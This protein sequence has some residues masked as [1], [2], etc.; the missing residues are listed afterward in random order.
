MICRDGHAENMACGPLFGVSLVLFWGH[1]AGR[2]N[3][4]FGPFCPDFGLVQ[5]AR[6]RSRRA[7]LQSQPP[8]AK[9][10]SKITFVFSL[11]ASR[12]PQ[13]AES[14]LNE[15]SFTARLCR[16]FSALAANTACFQIQTIT[17]LRDLQGAPPRAR[18]LY[19]TFPSA[20]GPSLQSVKSTLSHL[21]SCNPV[22]G[23]P[24]STS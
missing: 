17:Y 12:Q 5:E 18:Q 11:E 1:F 22:R 6:N 16:A 9:R 10:W 8:F 15:N 13:M 19:F 20:P 23:T 3:P 7:N 2:L 14:L 4:F 24:S 21:K